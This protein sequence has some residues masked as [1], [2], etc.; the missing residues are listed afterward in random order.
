M[1]L[2]EKMMTSMKTRSLVMVFR[3]A[4]SVGEMRG[5]MGVGWRVD[6]CG[7]TCKFHGGVS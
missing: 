5:E 3:S 4:C 1:M 7:H 2:M 6:R